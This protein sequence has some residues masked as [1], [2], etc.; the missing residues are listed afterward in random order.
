RAGLQPAVPRV[1]RPLRLPPGGLP[2]PPAAGQGL[3]L[4]LHLFRSLR[5]NLG[6]STWICPL[7]ALLLE[8]SVRAHG[9]VQVLGFVIVG[10]GLEQSAAPPVVD[11]RRVDSQSVG[12]FGLGQHPGFPEAV[13]P[14]PEPTL[15][16]NPGDDLSRERPSFP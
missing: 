8:R 1:R 2:P 6:E 10:M 13:K 15:V 7:D 14:A 16:P 12:D 9:L 11:R 5:G 3:Y 4:I